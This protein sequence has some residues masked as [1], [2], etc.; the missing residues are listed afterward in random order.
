MYKEETVKLRIKSYLKK[1]TKNKDFWI[2]IIAALF[3]GAGLTLSIFSL[4][5]LVKSYKTTN[6][7]A[8]YG[9]AIGSG[10]TLALAGFTQILVFLHRKRD[11]KDNKINK[12]EHDF[13]N[14]FIK[15]YHWNDIISLVLMKVNKELN[16][17][18]EFKQSGEVKIKYDYSIFNFAALR[19]EYVSKL[20][21]MINTSK[22][23]IGMLDHSYGLNVNSLKAMDK[24]I[25][26]FSAFDTEVKKSA[27]SVE[28]ILQAKHSFKYED[29]FYDLNMRDRLDSYVKTILP[30]FIIIIHDNHNY[31][32]SINAFDLIPFILYHLSVGD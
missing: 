7:L 13:T 4:I 10:L 18:L 5:L 26:L 29:D 19:K 21:I 31:N 2:W 3:I 9:G 14:F 15:N 16:I 11:A 8:A 17:S 1:R 24:V 6:I 20:V 12:T 23:L 30:Y 27:M 28:K 32:F 25:A 22:H